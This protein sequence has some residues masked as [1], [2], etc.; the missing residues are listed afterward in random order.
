MDIKNK[1]VVI[2]GDHHNTLGIIESFGE[3]GIKPYAIIITSRKHSYVCRSKY[4]AE[5]WCCREDKEVVEYLLR[6]FTDKTDKAVAFTTSDHA[7][8]ILDENYT[9]LCEV[10][11]IPT[12]MP[13][14]NLAEWMSKEKMSALAKEVG[15]NVPETWLVTNNALPSG[16]EYPVITKAISSV[17][18]T[19]A[20]I[21]I[22]QNESEL[23]NFL[24]NQKHC[25]EIQVQRFI[26]KAFEFQLLGCSISHGEDIIIPGRT[27]IDRPN[28]LDNTFFL[29]FDKC[30]NQLS[31]LIEK[32]KEFIRRTGYSGLFSVEFLRDK[33]GNDFF[34][35]MNFRND[36]NA[37][38]VTAAGTNIPYIYYLATIG[39][40][41][42]TE[43][44]NSEVK[45][46]YL[47]PEFYYFQRLLAGEISIKEWIRNA[48]KTNCYTTYFKNDK[49]PFVYFLAQKIQRIFEKIF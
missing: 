46:I 11:H 49:K 14:G 29:S 17:A 37:I 21:K 30:E 33:N 38:C 18:G 47:M 6:N 4:V 3:K 34:T 16:I 36:G 22:C 1:I 35:E 10:L 2:G 42:K 31:S 7:A 48:R 19:K 15:L 9:S 20:N 5:G 26:D 45:K 44:K 24:Q 8:C 28:G 27:H 13:H 39:Q 43:I 32:T 25:P 41:Y 12:T 23:S 40:D